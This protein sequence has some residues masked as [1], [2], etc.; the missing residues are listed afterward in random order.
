[1]KIAT[2]AAAAV[3]VAAASSTAQQHTPPQIPKPTDSEATKQ[4]SCKAS[5][6]EQV[7]WQL[8]SAKRLREWCRDNGYITYR[9]QLDA[10]E[11][12][13]QP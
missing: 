7:G 4:E 1:M 2:I 6:S 8:G 9:Q 11:M 13:K 10:E 5:L 3:L 12:V